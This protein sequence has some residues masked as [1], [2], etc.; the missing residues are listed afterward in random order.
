MQGGTLPSGRD[1]ITFLNIKRKTTE[2]KLII[3]ESLVKERG[4]GT[5]PPLQE[6]LRYLPVQR[7]NTQNYKREHTT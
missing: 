6:I 4:M 2:R 3:K 5:P 7:C 1:F